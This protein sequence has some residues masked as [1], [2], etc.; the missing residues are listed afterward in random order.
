MTRS[1]RFKKGKCRILGI[2]DDSHEKNRNICSVKLTDSFM[3]EE[4]EKFSDEEQRQ[5][6]EMI[7]LE[8]LRRSDP[9]AYAAQ[10]E[11]AHKHKS[12]SDVPPRTQLQET[13]YP[14]PQD[15]ANPSPINTTELLRT[16]SKSLYARFQHSAGHISNQP[17]RLDD[18]V[19]QSRE[20]NGTLQGRQDRP[21]PL[22]PL[23]AIRGSL[24][25]V[26]GQGVRI[27]S[28]SSSGSSDASEVGDVPGAERKQATW[29]LTRHISDMTE[30]LKRDGT[31]FKYATHEAELTLARQMEEDFYDKRKS[32][33]HYRQIT[34]QENFQSL[35]GLNLKTELDATEA[36]LAA[37]R[38][39]PRVP[40]NDLIVISSESEQDRPAPSALSSRRK[41]R[42]SPGNMTS[43]DGAE[44]DISLNASQK[45]S[46]KRSKT[47]SVRQ[48]STVRST[49]SNYSGDDNFPS[50]KKM[51]NAAN[52]GPTAT[53]GRKK[54]R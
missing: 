11:S 34:S 43:N 40:K 48:K 13:V 47:Q 54:R 8:R 30:R 20:P 17:Q 51:Y 53:D 2:Y 23:P 10:A 44:S 52:T 32:L 41:R 45:N 4:R 14:R 35:S 33:S 15:G 24:Q 36:K 16:S 21:D 50:I 19:Q 18:Q 39:K 31:M 12:L 22:D 3:E 25:P 38:S 42:L 29:A 7:R 5:V 37:T 26:L 46:T 27:A 1:L 28:A 9:A 6:D 49:I